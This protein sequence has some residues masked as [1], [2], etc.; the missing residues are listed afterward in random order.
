MARI[1]S[2]HPGF[3]TDEE[4]VTVSFSARLL[5][6]GLGVEADDKG[7]FEWKPL[8]IKMKVF[9]ADNVD[10]DVLLAE[11]EH[12]NAVRKY[13]SAGRQ[14]GAIR[15]FRKHQRPK[16]PNDI[17]PAGPEIRNY[18]GLDGSISETLPQSGGTP[19]EIRPQ[20]EDVGCRMEDGGEKKKEGGGAPAKRAPA[21]PY[22]FEGRVVRLN[23]VD[24]DTWRKTYHAIPDI[25]AELTSLDAWLSGQPPEKRKNW[26]HVASGSLNRKHQEIL[27]ASKAA[28]KAGDEMELPIA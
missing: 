16:T 14:Y 5:V 12:A 8:T 3:F 19:S 18:V 17:H 10:I 11:L 23:R 7:T 6:L 24:F 20:M 28:A 25:A 15:N 27:S 9:P 1:R 2:L 22:A 13:E 21:E 4:L 26:F